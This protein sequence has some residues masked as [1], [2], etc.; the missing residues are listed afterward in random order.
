MTKVY[1][2]NYI[3]RAS[4]TRKAA[5]TKAKAFCITDA[6]GVRSDGRWLY[7]IRIDAIDKNDTW[8]APV[9]TLNAVL[10][11]WNDF[12]DQVYWESQ[13]GKENPCLP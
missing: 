5:I 4:L 6:W 7:R 2:G 1:R 8:I 10:I 3:S 12:I 13:R 9:N 11:A